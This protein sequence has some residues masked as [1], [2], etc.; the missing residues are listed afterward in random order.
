MCCRVMNSYLARVKINEIN[1]INEIIIIIMVKIGN[2]RKP[3]CDEQSQC[4][5]LQTMMMMMMM[6]MR[7]G[8]EEVV[9][10]DYKQPDPFA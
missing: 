6:M 4:G 7:E 10:R 9:W 3:T 1:E 8:K 5:N 2:E